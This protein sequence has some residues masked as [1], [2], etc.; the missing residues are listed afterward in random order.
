MPLPDM[1]WRK[2]SILAG[3]LSERNPY[4]HKLADNWAL[5]EKYPY[6]IG[7]FKWTAWDYLGSRD[8]LWTWEK[9]GASFH[10]GY[11]WLLQIQGQWIFSK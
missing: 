11:P 6:L 7:D 9:D 8:G 3:L 5:V 10:K 1:P 2:K 4:C